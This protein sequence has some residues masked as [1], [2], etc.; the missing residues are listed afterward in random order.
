LHLGGVHNVHFLL[1]VMAGLVP[2]I[3][4][5][6]VAKTWMPDTRPRL[7]GLDFVDKAHGVDSSMF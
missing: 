2:A 4:V 6:A 5:L 7:S 1:P 3:H